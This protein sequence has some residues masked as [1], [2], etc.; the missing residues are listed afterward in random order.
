MNKNSDSAVV[1][2]VTP[3]GKVETARVD[4]VRDFNAKS[5]DK[6]KW[7]MQKRG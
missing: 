4:K 6:N 3:S 5:P 2:F 1:R 7:Q